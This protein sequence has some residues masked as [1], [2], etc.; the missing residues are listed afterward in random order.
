MCIRMRIMFYEYFNDIRYH[1]RLFYIK[2]NNIVWPTNLKRRDAWILIASGWFAR[3]K[4]SVPN[5][6]EERDRS[7]IVKKQKQNL[8]PLLSLTSKFFSSI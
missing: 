4:L 5:V 8:T 1:A 6:V 7:S 2:S 3:E